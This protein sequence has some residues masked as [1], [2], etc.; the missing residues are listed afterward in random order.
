MGR[1][2]RLSQFSCISADT[3]LSTAAPEH[4]GSTISSEIEPFAEMVIERL[5]RED[6]AS[7]DECMGV[8]LC[9]ADRHALLINK[10]AQFLRTSRESNFRAVEK[11]VRKRLC[12]YAV[13]LWLRSHHRN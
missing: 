6:D 12:E 5:L 4:V 7:W 3:A 10:A 11:D 13:T 1:Y 8:G 9:A 2:D